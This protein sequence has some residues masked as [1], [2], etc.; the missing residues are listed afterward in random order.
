MAKME[1]NRDS[2]DIKQSFEQNELSSSAINTLLSTVSESCHEK[3]FSEIL[4]D[5]IRR[6]SSTCEG[7]LDSCTYFMRE[8]NYLLNMVFRDRVFLDYRFWVYSESHMLQDV[9]K[10]PLPDD[11]SCSENLRGEEFIVPLNPGSAIIT[12][13]VCQPE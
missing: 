2:S 8:T 9:L 12:L 7:A 4:T 5:C 13:V 1:Q 3:T 10:T 11:S 6:P